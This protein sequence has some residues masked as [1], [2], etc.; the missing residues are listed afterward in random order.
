MFHGK[1]RYDGGMENPPGRR[2]RKREQTRRSIAGAAMRLFLER[3][4]DAVTIA[5]VAEAADVSVNTV[6]NHFPTKEDLFFAAHETGESAMARMAADRR[7]GEPVVAFLR[8][9]LE[10]GSRRFLE[11][12]AGRGDH[13]YRLGIRR[14]L[15]GSPALQVR[16]AHVAR[17]SARGAE[18]A[19]AASLARDAGEGPDDP[20]A[21]LIAGLVLALYSAVFA[22]AERRQRA[23][24]S[25]RTIRA[26]LNSAA[27]AALEVLERGVGDYGAAAPGKSL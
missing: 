5:E 25:P 26:S 10:E 4:F 15:Q 19:L 9:H 6:F 27:S 24:A 23:G 20:K 3:G 13:E 17:G 11:D 14:V 21:R 1:N 16:A 12:A 8:R 2:E 7:P 22:E 18:E